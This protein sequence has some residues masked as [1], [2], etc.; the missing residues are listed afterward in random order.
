[1]GDSRFPSL[2]PSGKVFALACRPAKL[3][4]TKALES[5][6][7]NAQVNGVRHSVRILGWLPPVFGVGHWGTGRYKK[8][9]ILMTSPG[10]CEVSR[11][12][13]PRWKHCVWVI[14]ILNRCSKSSSMRFRS[15]HARVGALL[16]SST[17]IL[18]TVP[19]A[20]SSACPICLSRPARSI[21]STS[22]HATGCLSQCMYRIRSIHSTTMVSGGRL[23]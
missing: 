13:H 15:A 5:V 16:N 11:M 9:R 21:P 20:R 3:G 23:R 2:A 12:W 4:V 7:G 18:G 8:P 1:M 19:S 14:P 17:A 22:W 10:D 6:Q